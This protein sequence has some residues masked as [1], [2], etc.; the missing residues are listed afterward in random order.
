MSQIY[1]IWVAE[2]LNPQWAAWLG[3][4]EIIHP[5]GP[6]PAGSHLRGELPDQAALYGVLNRLRDLNLTL[7]EVKRVN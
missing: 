5:A 4:M 1:K 7:I 3:G 6:C 2:E